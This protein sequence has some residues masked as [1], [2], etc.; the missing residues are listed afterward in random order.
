VGVSEVKGREE[1]CLG[2]QGLTTCKRRE[3]GEGGGGG[4]SGNG[5]EGEL[6]RVQALQTTTEVV[7][8]SSFKCGMVPSTL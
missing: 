3:Q 8:T 1:L 4:R 2:L 7:Q 5:G 6:A